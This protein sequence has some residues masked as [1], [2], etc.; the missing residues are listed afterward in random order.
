MTRPLPAYTWDQAQ[1]LGLATARGFR[2]FAIA[3]ATVRSW[4]S[5]GLLTAVGKAPGGAHLYRIAD[6]SAV[7]GRPRKKPGRPVIPAPLGAAAQSAPTPQ[8]PEPPQRR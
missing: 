8:S 3:P 1:I 7:A 5:Q 2:A 6:V 4:A